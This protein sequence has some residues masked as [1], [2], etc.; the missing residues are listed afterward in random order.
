MSQLRQR[1]WAFF[2]FSPDGPD[3]GC[4]NTTINWPSMGAASATMKR[5]ACYRAQCFCHN[6]RIRCQWVLCQLP[7]HADLS[8]TCTSKLTHRLFSMPRRPE[9]RHSIS[10]S[11]HRKA[12][13]LLTAPAMRPNGGWCDFHSTCL[14][15]PSKSHMLCPLWRNCFEP[16]HNEEI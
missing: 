10:S 4:K 8:L 1:V 13:C 12:K 11:R 3:T 9:D 6:F 14:H 5:D 7:D 15:F 16:P 2:S